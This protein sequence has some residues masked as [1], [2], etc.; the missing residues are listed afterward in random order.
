MKITHVYTEDW[1]AVYINGTLAC[2][3]NPLDVQQVL[4]KIPAGQSIDEIDFVTACQE[5][6]DEAGKMPEKLEDVVLV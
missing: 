1:E 6:L 2:Q 3:N 5:W 4:G